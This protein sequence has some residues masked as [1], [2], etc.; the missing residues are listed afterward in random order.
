MYAWNVGHTQNGLTFKSF[1]TQ[2]VKIQGKPNPTQTYT[3]IITISSNR[4]E[5]FYMQMDK[6]KM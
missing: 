6:K 4:P 3:I 1:I 5:W 2:F